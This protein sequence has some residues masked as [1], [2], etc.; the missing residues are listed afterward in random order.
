MDQ[1]FAA[2]LGKGNKD[3][4]TE[5]QNNAGD[6]Q[7]GNNNNN[8]STPAQSNP[9]RSNIGLKIAAQYFKKFDIYEKTR[10]NEIEFKKVQDDIREVRELKKKKKE[11][12]EARKKAPKKKKK[13]KKK[14]EFE[15]GNV[16]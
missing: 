8:N 4:N 12:D 13:K 2:L 14:R 3:N 11:L 15:E 16:N 7:T 9:S 1:V 6:T 5:N 10:M